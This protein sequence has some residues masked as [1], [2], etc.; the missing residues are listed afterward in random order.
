MFIKCGVRKHFTNERQLL[1]IFYLKM[2]L[3]YQ[4]Y[5]SSAHKIT[6][7]LKLKMKSQCQYQERKIIIFLPIAQCSDISKANE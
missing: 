7:C 3:Q 6:L 1:Q 2:M 5:D 4:T